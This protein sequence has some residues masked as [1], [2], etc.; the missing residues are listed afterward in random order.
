MDHARPPSYATVDIH[1]APLGSH[2]AEPAPAPKQAKL[3]TVDD[4]LTHLKL[5]ECFNKLRRAI[6]FSTNLFGIR[7]DFVP[8]NV[9]GATRNETLARIR[10]KRWAIYVAKAVLRFQAWWTTVEARSKM[11]TESDMEKETYA[12]ITSNSK[13]MYLGVDNLPP[14]GEETLRTVYALRLT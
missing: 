11:L 10:E 8:A 13:P 4:N 2:E 1:P 12:T 9:E 5:L 3:P 6:S 14:I 7:D